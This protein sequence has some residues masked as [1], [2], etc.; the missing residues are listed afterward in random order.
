[1]DMQRYDVVMYGS[2]PW[3]FRLAGGADFYQ[4]IS[5]NR[6]T[7]GNHFIFIVVRMKALPNVRGMVFLTSKP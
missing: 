5:I 7:P 3:G 1:M 4:E 6:V 2:P